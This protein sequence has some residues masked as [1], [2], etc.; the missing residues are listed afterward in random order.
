MRQRA[1]TMGIGMA[2]LRLANR[3]RPDVHET[4]AVVLVAM[5]LARSALMWAGELARLRRLPKALPT[6]RRRVVL[7]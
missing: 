3:L 4:K 1:N 6:E 2:V 7:L 5:P